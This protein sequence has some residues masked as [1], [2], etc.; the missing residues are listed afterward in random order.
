MED[1]DDEDYPI[2]CKCCKGMVSSW[3]ECDRCDR[4]V[5]EDCI[6]MDWVCDLCKIPAN[7]DVLAESK[8]PNE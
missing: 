1:D 7:A 3:M 6:G 8:E 5:C 2:Q 4:L